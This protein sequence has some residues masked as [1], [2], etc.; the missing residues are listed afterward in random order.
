MTASTAIKLINQLK[1]NYPTAINIDSQKLAELWYESFEKVPDDKMEVAINLHVLSSNKF[2]TVFDLRLALTELDEPA[3]GNID[4]YAERVSR[5]VTPTIQ[6]IWKIVK[7]GS[8]NYQNMYIEPGILQFAREL[9]PEISEVLLK[10][11]YCQINYAYEHEAYCRQC[12]GK[13]NCLTKGYKPKLS[14][15]PK[16]WIA[17]QM[18]RCGGG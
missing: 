11:N 12:Q 10:K 18:C 7:S 5:E 1:N 15:H 14:L 2:P 16:G 9:F 3:G 17:V 13:E 8:F 6:E 4:K